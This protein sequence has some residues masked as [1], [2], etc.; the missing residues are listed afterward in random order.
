MSRH[1]ARPASVRTVRERGTERVGLGR[2]SRAGRPGCRRCVGP[3]SS[4]TSQSRVLRPQP[5]YR[6]VLSRPH[7]ARCYRWI[8]CRDHGAERERISRFSLPERAPAAHAARAAIDHGGAGLLSM[9][10][11]LLQT[12]WRL[13]QLPAPILLLGSPDLPWTTSGALRLSAYALRGRAR[14]V[15]AQAG[16]Y[17][18]DFALAHW[19]AVVARRWLAG[20]W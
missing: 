6:V 19:G 17:G 16:D 20:A 10:G 2:A 14:F 4:A 18:V 12:T 11:S 9:N 3:T 8:S 5:A 15:S 1:S 13:P 7:T